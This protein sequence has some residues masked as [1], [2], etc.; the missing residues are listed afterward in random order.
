V[1]A[2]AQGG[3]FR[4]L[5]PLAEAPF[6]AAVG[7]GLC[8]LGLVQL[9]LGLPLRLRARS[10]LPLPPGYE[11]S[12]RPGGRLYRA[13]TPPGQDDI[14]VL[15]KVPQHQGRSTRAAVVNT[16][17][18]R[19][20]S[21]PQAVTNATGGHALQPVVRQ[22]RW[23]VPGQPVGGFSLAAAG[24]T[25]SSATSSRSSPAFAG[26]HRAVHFFARSRGWAGPQSRP[27]VRRAS[28]GCFRLDGSDSR[29]TFGL[30]GSS[31]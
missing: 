19:R 21:I 2:S 20:T 23:N 17:W 7:L 30:A 31:G 26:P 5:R 12:R 28:A 25:C 13:T 15:A 1:A 16:T 6:V 27:P 18:F 4:L 8:Q 29:I 10:R 11:R 9:V 3:P 22:K 14:Q 24:G